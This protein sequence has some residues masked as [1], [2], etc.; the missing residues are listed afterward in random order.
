MKQLFILLIF[1][2]ITTHINAQQMISVIDTYTREPIANVI[3]IHDGKNISYTSPQGIAVLPKLSGKVTITAQD[4]ETLV[5][6][7]DSIPAIIHLQSKAKNLEEIVVLG[8]A[9]KFKSLN[10]WNNL[11]KSTHVNSNGSVGIGIDA[12]FRFFGY[13]PAS[14]RRR[15]RV[16]KLLKAYDEPVKEQKK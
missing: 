12:I 16:K 13:R 15:E 4:Y 6:H 2:I 1:N 3:F 5:F 7:A 10:K 11:K 9:N 14:E 8:D